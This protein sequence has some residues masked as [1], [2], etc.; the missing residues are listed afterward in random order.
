MKILYEEGEDLNN[1]KHLS[2][3]FMKLENVL[4]DEYMNSI[5]VSGN[6]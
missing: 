3:N 6:S 4:S 5:L 2:Q 1:V